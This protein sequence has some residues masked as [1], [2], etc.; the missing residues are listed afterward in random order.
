MGRIV[1][2]MMMSLDGY[3]AGPD[4]AI[5]LPVPEPELHWY[6][7]DLMKRTAVSLYGRRMYETMKVWQDWDSQP[8]VSD[9]EA[10]FAR[11]WRSV[12]K[13]VVSTTLTEVGPNARLVRGDVEAAVRELKAETQGEIAV[14]GAGLAGSLSKFGLIDEYQLFFQPVV[15]GGGK[16]F[17]QPG[18]PLHLKPLGWEELP[19]GVKLLRYGR[20]N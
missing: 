19:Q 13:V 1:Y 16:A 8:D 3:I 10:D 5:D 9:V 11:A 15:L 18:T 2:G 14:S 17:F 12:P 20:E 4:R 6:F 7:N